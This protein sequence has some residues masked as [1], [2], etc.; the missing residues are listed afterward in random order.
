MEGIINV[1]TS[2]LTKTASAFNGTGAEIKNLTNQMTQ[3]VTS[4]SGAIWSGDAATVYVN[5]F[6]GLQDD[7]NR[8][9]KMVEEHVND[10]QQMAS[11]YESA[12]SQNIDAANSLS[13][14]VIV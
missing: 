4:L 13:S 11:G 6:N 14:D 7:I 1:S 8:I 5:K 3:T 10:L 2:E 9:I 12:E